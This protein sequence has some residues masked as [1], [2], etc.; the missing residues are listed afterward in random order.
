MSIPD[1]TDKTP[2]DIISSDRRFDSAWYTFQAQ[3]WLDYAK[4]STNISALQY[5]ALELRNAI[6]QFW[7]EYLILTVGGVIDKNE[8]LKVK[9]NRTKLYKFLDKLTT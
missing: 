4:K 1:F 3:C 6:E 2:T 5:A 9:N 7:F 8:Y